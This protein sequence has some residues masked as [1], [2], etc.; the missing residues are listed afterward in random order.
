MKKIVQLFIALLGGAA[1][2][3]LV[4]HQLPAVERS[5]ELAAIE[6]TAGHYLEGGTSGDVERLRQAFHSST[7]LKFVKNGAV[8]EWPVDD[9]L[10]RQTPG[11]LS[12]RRT[13]ILLV[14]FAGTCAVVKAEIDYGE[15]RFI[16][17]LSLLKVGDDWKIVGKIFYRDESPS[18]TSSKRSGEE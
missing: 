11:K 12:E 1:I 13:R 6:A 9:Y 8:S 18:G 10:A 16:D 4:V 15:F 5:S 7:V 3:V 14:D 2:I 17:Y